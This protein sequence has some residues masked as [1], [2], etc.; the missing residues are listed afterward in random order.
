[1]WW[2]EYAGNA[3][4]AKRVREKVEKCGDSIRQTDWCENTRTEERVATKSVE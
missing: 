4:V 3:S 1:V 2:G